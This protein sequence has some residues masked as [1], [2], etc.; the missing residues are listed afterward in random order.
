MTLPL[1]AAPPFTDGWNEAFTAPGRPRPLYGSLLRA[2]V[3]VDMESLTD[4]VGESMEA[5]QATFGSDPLV[6]CPVPRLIDSGE[7]AVLS[8]G[9][10]QRVRALSAFLADAYGPRAIVA[11][12]IVPAA[13]ID[14]AEGYEP[15]LRGRWPGGAASLG[16]VGL[17][18]VRDRD[19][20]FC[21]LEDNARTPSG[22]AYAVAA[23]E[24]VTATLGDLAPAV[25]STTPAPVPLEPA[26][27]AALGA[28]M[29]DAAEAVR[30]G[31]AAAAGGELR[32]VVLTDGAG[33]SAFFEHATAARWLEAPL[34]TLDDL[35]RRG[36]EVWLR[37]GDAGPAWRVDAVLRRTDTDRLR[38]EHGSRTPVAELL[39]EPWLAGRLAVVN[40]FGTGVADDKLAHAYVEQMIRFYL[41]EE[42]LL[43]S[44]ET[45]DLN[46]PLVREHV[47]GDLHAHVIKPRHG[48]G[49]H[50]V[51]V[52]AHA[53]AADVLRMEEALRR[54]DAGAE[55]VAQPTMALSL[56]PTII[57]GRLAE[58][59]IDLRPFAFA[60]RDSVEVVPGGLTRVAREAGALVVN[61]S[62]EGG[63]KDTWVLA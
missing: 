51:V 47:L 20:Q 11:A 30:G 39:L 34:V 16:V 32:V 10:A 53:A 31:G 6:V 63:V 7:W 55:Y 17:D 59:H 27:V 4:A 44:V 52:C 21:V 50:G 18:V 40:A 5:A 28:T 43:R 14:D 58:R 46:D 42:P 22:F 38:D 8:A 33:S 41:G 60:T 1:P 57:D 36:D 26:I 23:R 35:E 3:S 9:L 25:G 62:Q 15:E 19:G 24:A 49:G 13:V 61:S 29:R 54:P 12:G 2:L 56:H 45:L 48:H 37:A